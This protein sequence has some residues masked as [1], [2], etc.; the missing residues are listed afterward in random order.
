MLLLQYPV[1]T[2]EVTMW[3]NR[4]ATMVITY[5]LVLNPELQEPQIQYDADFVRGTNEINSYLDTLE[6]FLKSWYE[7]RCDKYEF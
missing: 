3:E 7:D 1:N 6:D 2:P 5:A 4:L